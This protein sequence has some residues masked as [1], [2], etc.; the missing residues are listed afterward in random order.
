MTSRTP[1]QLRDDLVADI[2]RWGTF[3]TAQVEAAFRTVPRHLFLPDVDLETAYG[4]QVVVTRRAPDGTAL[5]SASQPSLV[6][7]MLE[8]ADVQPGHRV[9]EIGTATG[10]NAALLA[11]LTGP[12]GQ[13][14]T[15]E[16]DEDLAAGAR[17][18]LTTAGYERVD[19]IGG[20]GAAGH[21]GGAPYDR[22]VITAGAWDL[23]RG[24]WNQ[25]APAG[26]IVVPLRLHGSGLTRS[27]PLDA[28]EPG[29][30]VSRSALVCGF[31][32]LRGTDAHSGHVLTL[33]DGVTLRVD[34]HDPADETALRAAA[35]SPPHSLWTGLTIHDDEPTAHLDLWLVT[36]GARFGRLAVDTTI[37]HDSQLTPTRRWAGATIHDGTTIA[38][39]TLRP[40]APDT[41]EL[42]VTAHG[43]H[44]ATLAAHLTDLLHH[45]RKEGPAE[46]VITAHAADTPDDQT[47]AGHRIDRP[48]SRLTVRWQP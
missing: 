3:R 20:D 2:R 8:Q 48:N 29:R 16:I 15:I 43:P 19:V 34:D 46:P 24:W 9:L 36:V 28:V 30:L 26:R 4:P 14:T 44:A 38:Y 13:V 18:A 6:A 31:V 35:A 33:A 17:T 21:P 10:I 12:T 47:V 41:D 39:I 5:S 32:P 22:I 7:A 27:L 23:A 11:E 42:G 25:L 45:W 40:L 1:E 37:C